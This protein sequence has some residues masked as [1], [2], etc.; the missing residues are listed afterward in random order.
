M[1]RLLMIISAHTKNTENIQNFPSI[2]L[3]NRLPLLN[4]VALSDFY[5]SA[6]NLVH[7]LIWRIRYIL[8]L[9]NRHYRHFLNWNPLADDFWL[10]DCLNRV[11][12]IQLIFLNSVFYSSCSSPL[13]GSRKGGNEA[14]EV[15]TWEHSRRM[16][17]LV[18]W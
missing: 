4:S 15:S 14:S 1:Q 5:F 6:Y 8:L 2:L 17:H 3:I 11:V 12:C 13:R 16:D 9:T 10:H 7:L 18:V